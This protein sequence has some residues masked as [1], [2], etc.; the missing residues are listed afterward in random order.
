MKIQSYSPIYKKADFAK[1]FTFG[2]YPNDTLYPKHKN[3]E[4]DFSNYT[5]DIKSYTELVRNPVVFEMLPKYLELYYPDGAVIYDY[6]CS[7]GHEPCSLVMSLF[8][9]FP[10]EEAQKYLP[11][12]AIDLREDIIETAKKHSIKIDKNEMLKLTNIFKN[13]DLED[14]L[15]I[16]PNSRYAGYGKT[17]KLTEKLSDNINFQTGDIFADLKDNELSKKPCIVLFR[18]SWQYLS[19]D[20]AQNLTKLLAEKL[21]DGSTLIVGDKDIYDANVKNLLKKV[22]FKPTLFGAKSA[23][24]LNKEPYFRVDPYGIQHKYLLGDYCFK[25]QKGGLCK[26]QK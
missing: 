14:Y 5:N 4:K 11:I 9:Y 13:I 1:N 7:V 15:T 25:L 8:N 22:G 19:P 12:K 3:P 2:W 10:Q 16:E 23:E 20:G 21:P 6:A 17:F 26:I 24:E 18:N